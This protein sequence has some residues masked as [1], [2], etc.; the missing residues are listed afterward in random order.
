[1]EHMMKVLRDLADAPVCPE[2]NLRQLRK[3]G[4]VFLRF[5]GGKRVPATHLALNTISGKD[6]GLPVPKERFLEKLAQSHCGDTVINDEGKKL[7]VVSNDRAAA[8][9]RLVDLEVVKGLL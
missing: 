8:Y 2:G 4:G 3:T 1:M 6:Y 5:G 7:V 9:V